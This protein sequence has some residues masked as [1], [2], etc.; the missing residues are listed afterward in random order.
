MTPIFGNPRRTT[1]HD[2]AP[3]HRQH[4]L[5]WVTMRLRRVLKGSAITGF[6]IL[7]LLYGRT[8]EAQETTDTAT[9]SGL[10]VPR[11]V[12]LKTDKVNLRAGPSQNYPI[13]LVYVRKGLPLEVIAE[14]ELWRRVRDMDGEEGWVHSA[15]LDGARYLFVRG[16]GSDRAVA[17]RQ[18][19]GRD[20]PIDSLA[21]PGVIGQLNKCRIDW[22]LMEAQ[23]QT[24]WVHR[25]LVWG[26]YADE[27]I[28]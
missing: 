20:A 5:Y 8:S 22:C 16:D 11:F 10:Q 24:G 13:K 4:G 7:C 23:G 3:K 12:S 1:S 25:S 6:M 27:T 18:D 28:K 2:H 19:P 14:S 26:V 15:T 9:F 17:L 21:Q